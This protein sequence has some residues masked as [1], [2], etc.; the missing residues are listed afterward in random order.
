[1]S[2]RKGSSNKPYFYDES[3]ADLV[4]RTDGDNNGRILIGHASNSLPILALFPDNA[5]VSGAFKSTNVVTNL[6]SSTGVTIGMRN[7]TDEHPPDSLYEMS[8]STFPVATF[9]SN[10]VGPSFR[11]SNLGGGSNVVYTPTDF[12]SNLTVEGV[13]TAASN[14]DLKGTLTASNVNMSGRLIAS[15]VDFTG[16]VLFR[17]MQLGQVA[18]SYQMTEYSTSSIVGTES[19]PIAGGNLVLDTSSTLSAIVELSTGSEPLS[20]E[21]SPS[22]SFDTSQV[23]KSGNIVLV[24]RSTT[25]RAFS[26]D[27]RIHF[28][29]NY[30]LTSSGFNNASL[31]STTLY[32]A[33]TTTAAPAPGGFAV[34]TIDYYIPKTGFAIGNYY[35]QFKCMPPSFD[36][37]GLTQVTHA[38][39]T[40]AAEYTLDVAGF[41][42]PTYTAY[43]GPLVYSLSSSAPS[44][45][46]HPTYGII[47]VSK[48]TLCSESIV[49]SIQGITG[50]VTQAI[51]LDVKPWYAPFIIDA[52]P[53]LPDHQ[54]TST[55]SYA[56]PVPM[57]EHG[58]ESTG[59]LTWSVGSGL[60]AGTALDTSTGQ[61]TFM[62]DAAYS[63]TVTLTATGPAPSFYTT[64]A[65]FAINVVNWVAP[66]IDDIASPQIGSTVTEPYVIKPVHTV[67]NNSGTLVWS[68]SP[69][70]LLSTTGVTFDPA[71]GT[72][73]VALRTALSVANVTITATGPT[74]MYASRSFAISLTP[75][76]DPTFTTDYV[77]ETHDTI[78]SPYVLA[79]PTVQ[80][81]SSLTGTLIWSVTPASLD[82]YLDKASGALMFPLHYSFQTQSVTLTATGPLGD[83][84]SDTFLLTI[85]PYA[86]PVI[87][88][89]ADVT[90]YTGSGAF[91]LAAPAQ[92]V[93]NTGAITW[94][95]SGIVPAGVSISA[96]TGIVTVTQST[97]FVATSIT[98][99]ATGPEAAIFGTR[100]FFL[101]AALWA[102][103]VV[104]AIADQKG[105]TVL[106][107]FVMVAPTVVTLPAYT[108]TLTWSVTPA[109]LG[110]YLNS[111][112]GALSFPLDYYLSTTNV[113]LIATGPSGLTSANTFALNVVPYATPAVA[114]IAD[115]VAYT[116]SGVF[117][118]G[119]PSQTVLNTGTLTWSLTGTVP[120]GV[121][122]NASTGVIA[123]VQ[124]TVFVATSLTVKATGPDP[125][126]YGTTTFQLTAALWAAPAI[127]P[128]SAQSSIAPFT[129]VLVQT[130]ALAYTGTL[131]WSIST[132]DSTLATYFNT[133]TGVLSIPEGV[134]ISTVSVTITVAS[135][136]GMSSQPA[137]FSFTITPPLYLYTFTSWTFTNAGATG[138]T[139]PTIT[140]ARNV[141]TAS[142][143]GAWVNTYLNMPTYQGVQEWTVPEDGNYRFNVVGA[144]PI[145]SNT[146]AVCGRPANLTGTV[147]LTKNTVICIVVGQKGIASGGFPTGGGASVAYKKT[148][149]VLLFCAGGGGATNGLV[150]C[151]ASLTQYATRYNGTTV[152][153]AFP[154][155]PEYLGYDLYT[156]AFALSASGWLSSPFWSGPLN[157][158]ALGAVN[159]ASTGGFGGGGPGNSSFGSGGGYTS[160]CGPTRGN[161]GGGGGGS[162]MISSATN[163]TSSINAY[164][165]WA[166][167]DGKVSVTRM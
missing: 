152:S 99:K 53:G 120:T 46:I 29:T 157:G 13:L 52:S 61:L 92:E 34:D 24:E 22:I 3:A 43:Y 65:S 159:G 21:L 93:T 82:G 141:Y 138:A 114:V 1:M 98:V 83:T 68:L 35:R 137:T 79:G 9:A 151:D 19:A 128:I 78:N 49:V 140:M 167:A 163:V 85:V 104:A 28:A 160:G 33:I 14:V 154:S 73:S 81:A 59:G 118:L 150:G 72:L 74:G 69:G 31:E 23:G 70:S 156:K 57:M 97:V 42:I 80:Q 56:L 142:N 155:N 41:L 4:W 161:A 121:S 77:T 63:G 147:A 27:P 40:N 112:S 87:S 84:E 158:S 136:G 94:S 100:S 12:A 106:V 32:G 38:G 143:A 126:E 123:V 165:T 20:I 2:I 127:S 153:V 111:S 88:S 7:P 6:V 164:A 148:G 51:M 95:L 129:L 108:G 37:V 105:Y 17:G 96:S 101:T 139:G 5:V 75:W 89:I 116:G 39:I 36:E 110:S 47:T 25:G 55:A 166:G 71:S 103:P 125:T 67:G 90:A 130:V 119:A 44:V 122:I 26:L 64:S 30:N 54:S 113:T 16:T 109:N 149:T 135:Q 117:L 144:Q 134:T 76:A 162:Y 11:G 146:S 8:A 124:N 50:T 102:A 45:S 91:L 18:Q 145:H 10:M 58:I 131:T 86:T 132:T 62:Q 66:S 48:N 107:P 15:N 133:T 115:T 60:P